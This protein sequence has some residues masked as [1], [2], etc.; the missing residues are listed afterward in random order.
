MGMDVMEGSSL[1][2]TERVIEAVP[3]A[4]MVASVKW[5]DAAKGFGFLAPGGGLPDIFCPA[6]A[7]EAVGLATL[8]DG[9]SVTCEV[10]Q[11]GKGPQVARIHA[12]EF[13]SAASVQAPGNGR[14]TAERGLP[15]PYAGARGGPVT[16]TVK[17]FM[18]TKGYGF[19]ERRDGSGDLFCHLTAVQASGYETLVQGATVTCE[20]VDTERG[21]QVSR[22][23]AVDGPPGR[24]GGAADSPP[25]DGFADGT[26]QDDGADGAAVDVR[27]TVKFYDPGKGYGFIVPDGGGREVFVHMS[28]LS[29][30]GLDELQPGQRVS[31]W[32]EEVPRGVQ[33]TEIELI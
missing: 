32:A 11:G 13:P 17:W 12:V 9:A 29:R 26:W 27:G 7:L 2:M 3:G 16:G 28:A 4:R 25:R 23:I 22:I 15:Q 8:V 24:S 1:G 19:L 30:S 21:A 33:A 14:A 6:S 31:V 20:V 5:Y 10:T 18:P